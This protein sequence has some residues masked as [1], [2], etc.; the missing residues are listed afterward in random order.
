ML[1]RS[2]RDA[3]FRRG[4]VCPDSTA[5]PAPVDPL[6][7]RAPG[8]VSDPSGGRELAFVKVRYKR[9][10]GTESRLMTR[11]LRQGAGAG[12]G[13]ADFRFAAAVAGFGMLLRHSE[14]RG[15]ITAAQVLALARSGLGDD[16]Q[17]YRHGFLELVRAYQELARGDVADGR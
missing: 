4:A 10:H 16:P 9:S 1:F 13:S 8:R 15:S 2:G 11:A 14:H 7:Y 12:E 3:A 6:R 17:G 5:V